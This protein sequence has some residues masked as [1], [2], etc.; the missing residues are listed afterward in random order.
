M[1]YH[2]FELAFLVSFKPEFYSILYVQQHEKNHH[3]DKKLQSATDPV[4]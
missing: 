3:T 2:C 4:R 1:C